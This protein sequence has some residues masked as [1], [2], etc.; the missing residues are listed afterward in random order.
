M[1]T[2]EKDFIE[3][4][5]ALE[6]ICRRPDG[7]AAASLKFRGS[8]GCFHREHSPHAFAIMDK[9]KL[10]KDGIVLEDHESGP[11]YL[12]W[13]PVIVLGIGLAD[14]IIGLVTTLLKARQEGAMKGDKRPANL[15]FIIRAELPSS[16]YREKLI[17]TIEADKPFD[18][19]KARTEIDALIDEWSKEEKRKQK[20]PKAKKK[21]S[22]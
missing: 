17:I 1:G 14:K 20:K 10:E 12:I 21:K 6:R 22:T 11:E 5:D 4:F 16:G 8:G 19:A 13:I 15:D 7:A 3:R 18:E 2:W 9:K